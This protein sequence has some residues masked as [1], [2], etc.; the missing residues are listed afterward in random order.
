MADGGLVWLTR[1]AAATSILLVVLIVLFLVREALPVVRSVGPARFF[2]DPAWHP[3]DG[4]YGMAPML[5]GSGLTTLGALLL[6]APLGLFSALFGCFYAP[7]AV[8]GVYRRIIE[9]LA[10]IPSVVY[11]LWG[12]VVLVP[13]INRVRPP[14]ASLLTAILILALM[15]LPTLALT[16]EAGLRAVPREHLQAAAALGLSQWTT[17]VRIAIPAARSSLVTAVMLATGRALGE[18]MAVLMV[19][20]NVVQV[21]RSLFD[22]V[23]T[24]TANIALEMA[25]AMGDHRAALFVSGLLLAVVVTVFVLAAELAHR[26][27]SHA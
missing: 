19:C 12:L 13:L 27:G 3:T 23:R 22:P 25:Y 26:K 10:G 7:P 15:I 5:W 24:L 14:G 17:I 11:G 1:A 2:T 20:G 8:A 9:L 21:P 16:A 18:T 6:A 4:E